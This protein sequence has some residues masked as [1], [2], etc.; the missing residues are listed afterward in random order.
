MAT[1]W[2]NP[3]EVVSSSKALKNSGFWETRQ[4]AGLPPA[5]ETDFGTVRGSNASQE[6][7][8][9]HS[10]PRL[11]PSDLRRLIFPAARCLISAPRRFGRFEGFSSCDEHMFVLGILVYATT[12]EAKIP[13]CAKASAL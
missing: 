3:I 2:I 9:L 12:R 1:P 6:T 4:H 11:P 7:A 13:T 10:R 5:T 8:I